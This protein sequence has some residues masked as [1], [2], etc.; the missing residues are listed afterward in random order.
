[1]NPRNRYL[2]VHGRKPVLEALRDPELR[3][4]KVLVADDAR[5]PALEPVLT[6]AKRRGVTI[7]RTRESRLNAVART[8]RHQ[9][10]VAD[11]IA[12]NLAGLGEF[13]ER[14]RGG[15]AHRTAVLVLDGVT[16]PANVGMVLRSATAAGIE[17][18]V[19]PEAGT[20][21]LGPLV[22][23]ASA[24]VAFRSPIVRSAT[25]AE[26]LDALADE[27]FEIVGLDTHPDAVDLFAAPLPERVA[28]V[29]GNEASG[30]SPE[31]RERVGA[32]RS[33]PL[34]AGVE[35]L[36]VACAATLVAYEIT[37]RRTA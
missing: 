5:G 3:I 13:C 15:R 24:G 6:E 11:V 35:S 7:E 28:F 9:G 17:G 4:A 19:V 23:K 8:S 31:A 16:T 18:V 10:V 26:A 25:T 21:E 30:L 32:Y 14:R 2:A 27:R 20:A 29:V 33:I 37:R 34:A 1:M 36:N 22:I 12:P